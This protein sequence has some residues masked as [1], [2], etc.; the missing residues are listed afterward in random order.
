M[1]I[2]VMKTNNPFINNV[3]ASNAWYKV[4]IELT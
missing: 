2:L 4:D 1:K 3:Y